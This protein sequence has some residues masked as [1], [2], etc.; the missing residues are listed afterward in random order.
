MI[1]NLV[2]L[3]C[4][5][6]LSTN[7]YAGFETQANCSA[8]TSPSACDAKPGC[9]WL[10][11]TGFTGFIC[12]LC[13]ANNY[14]DGSG[15]HSCPNNSTTP[16]NQPG[17]T[18]IDDC[19]CNSSYFKYYNR[20]DSWISSVGCMVAPSGNNNGWVQTNVNSESVYKCATH[21][22]LNVTGTQNPTCTCPNDSS[23]SGNDCVCNTGYRWTGTTDNFSC[24]RCPVDN[25]SP[26]NGTCECNAGYYG[27]AN[28]TNGSC[29]QCPAGYT[30][31]PGSNTQRSNCYMDSNTEFCDANGNCMKLLHDLSG[32]IIAPNP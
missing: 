16:N 12:D 17:A 21:A 9:K 19:T 24:T 6:S 18:S 2:C 27:D 28:V 15:C 30:S 29:T 4:L 5:L 7:V 31:D 11:G 8:E 25:S 22:T 10:S 13:T 20:S 23:L 1:K 26:V 32:R 14:N 3:L